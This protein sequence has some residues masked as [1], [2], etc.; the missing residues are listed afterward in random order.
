MYATDGAQGA[1]FVWWGYATQQSPGSYGGGATPPTPP[2]EYPAAGTF[3][4]SA[5]ELGYGV[6]PYTLTNYYADGNGGEYTTSSDYST[7]CGY[8]DFSS[9]G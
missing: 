6:S 7:T 2:V 4:R 3:L 5:C 9:G 8:V 1:V